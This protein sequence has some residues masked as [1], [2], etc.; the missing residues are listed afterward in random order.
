MGEEVG[1]PRDHAAETP[2]RTWVLRRPQPD[3]RDALAIAAPVLDAMFLLTGDLL[4]PIQLRAEIGWFDLDDREFYGNA[5]PMEWRLDRR[6]QPPG[7]EWDEWP[8]PQT[9]ERV[10]A[11]DR[12]A[13]ERFLVRA[14]DRAPR[15]DGMIA[16]PFLIV[17]SAVRVR[18]LDPVAADLDR[19]VLRRDAGVASVAIERDARGVWVSG[20]TDGF[21]TPPVAIRGKLDREPMEVVVAAHWTPWS[22]EDRPGTRAVEEAVARVAAS[23]WE[24]EE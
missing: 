19:L 7:R 4:E 15:D 9:L 1:A 3:G 2:L 23:G 24:V 8:V 22:E 11:V 13:V 21:V 18:L 12:A 20:P 14:C 16:C 5:S 6:V 17:V 10:D